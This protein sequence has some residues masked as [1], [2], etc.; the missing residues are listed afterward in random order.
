MGQYWVVR[1]PNC[2]QFTYTDKYGKWKLCPLC[3]EVINVSQ[4]LVYLEVDDFSEAEVLLHAVKDYLDHT[5][6][7]DLR[8][9]EVALIRER[10]T[11]WLKNG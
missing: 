3:G 5:G 2:R 8:P 6:R 4:V 11:E 1:C 10:Y 9:E 7:L